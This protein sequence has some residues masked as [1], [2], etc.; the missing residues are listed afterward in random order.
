M[1]K[2]AACVKNDIIVNVAVYDEE[3][4]QSWFEKSKLD[5]DEIIITDEAAI[6][7]KVKDGKVIKPKQPII[8]ND[9]SY[10]DNN[11]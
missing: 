10:M 5:F 8:E 3:T 2:T 11:Q 1:I 7:W 9:L 4:S 6:G